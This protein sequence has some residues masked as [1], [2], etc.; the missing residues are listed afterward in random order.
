MKK[1]IAVLALLLLA[2]KVV[3]W[4]YVTSS[5]MVPNQFII[6][7]NNTTTY[8][9][10]TNVQYVGPDYILRFSFTTNVI[11][12]TY[13]GFN[14]INGVPYATNGANSIIYYTNAITGTSGNQTNSWPLGD[15]RLWPDA[16]VDSNQTPLTMYAVMTGDGGPLSSNL[17][18][19][20]CVRMYGTNVDSGGLGFGAA[21][22]FTVAFGYAGNTNGVGSTNLTTIFQQGASGI[23]IA[24]IVTA[25]S[26]T[27]LFTKVIDIGVSGFKQ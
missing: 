16:N 13:V 21:N 7:T 22:T 24:K 20:T 1:F 26:S 5:F 18:T 11:T 15:V 25:N 12:P 2:A 19:L 14:F 9:G 4:D 8:W 17:V 3:A 10:Y 23:R 27:N 6:L